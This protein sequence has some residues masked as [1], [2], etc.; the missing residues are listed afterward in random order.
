M[1]V[2][3]VSLA[4]ESSVGISKTEI[5]FRIF[6][7]SEP[8]LTGRDFSFVEAF[9][10]DG[11]LSAKEEF[12]ADDELS[13]IEAFFA[14]GKLSVAG[15]ALIDEVIFLRKASSTAV[16]LPGSAMT[17]TFSAMAIF[18]ITLEKA[19]CA[20]SG[21]TPQLPGRTG[22]IIIVPSCSENSAGM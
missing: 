16:L 1:K 12:F 11:K 8:S 2:G 19:F 3:A 7:V 9:F 13:A 17:M 6:P 5:F 20:F 21:L 15:S 10:A 18:L 22:Q 4:Q 14:D